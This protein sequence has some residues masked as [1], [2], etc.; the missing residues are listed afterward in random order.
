MWYTFSFLYNNLCHH[1]IVGNPL[2]VEYNYSDHKV[3][4]IGCGNWGKN[5]VRLFHT[6]GALYTISDIDPNHAATLG[7]QF[8]IPPLSLE[9]IIR[10]P[11]IEA[12][13]I[14]TPAK[15]HFEIAKRCLAAKKHVFIEK[16]MTIN[17]HQA[18]YLLN[19]SRANECVLMVGHLLHYHS[20]FI[21]LK[22]LI[23]AGEL[24]NVLHVIS[25]RYTF[26]KL[27]TEDSVFWD[28]APH[29]ISMIL[30]LMGELPHKVLA[31]ASHHLPNRWHDMATIDLWFSQQRHAQITLSWLHPIK[32]QSFN[33]IGDRAM[34]TFNDALP[35]E[36]KLR[37]FN[38]LRI[39]P[40]QPEEV[41]LEPSEPLMNEC[42]HFLD[43]IIQK[44]VPRTDAEEAL[45][46]TRVLEAAIGSAQ[47]SI[48]L[49]LNVDLHESQPNV[50][51]LLEA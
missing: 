32:E 37:L 28:L 4:V 14:V 15:T 23:Q 31:T 10:S 29:D 39:L 7:K 18:E 9:E 50:P 13:V 27:S 22:Q 36:N 2:S 21:K 16:P 45:H 20:A 46:V 51:V 19:M 33:V 5:H 25:H 6:L 34:V 42:K 26:G 48:P 43:C 49:S 24:G 17:S 41:H 35:W 1:Y 30:S 8:A 47:S 38:Q 40:A 44:K 11:Q 12:C 3:A